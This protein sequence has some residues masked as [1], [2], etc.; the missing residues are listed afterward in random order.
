MLKP[1][2]VCFVAEPAFHVSE[3]ALSAQVKILR[4]AGLMEIARPKV[5][6]S[7]AAVLRKPEDVKK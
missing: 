5:A 1:G 2:G 7:R 6:F 3:T 4:E